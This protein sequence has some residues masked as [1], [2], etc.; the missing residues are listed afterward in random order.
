M[1]NIGEILVADYLRYKE[2][3]DF[4]DFN[5]STTGIQGEIDVVGLN[6]K[7]KV[8]FICEVAVHLVS[9][10]RYVSKSQPNT[11][12]KLLNK[13]SKDIGYAERFF[14]K[15]KKV[16][17]L[18]SPLVKTSKGKENQMG[19]IQRLKADLKKEHGVEIKIFVN[20]EFRKAFEFLRSFAHRHKPELKSPVMR[21]LQIDAKTE[22]FSK[23]IKS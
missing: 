5:V 23:E 16:F 10:L 22:R 13:F 14:P 19:T 18:W 9:G 1:P 11:Y 6:N 17:M 2:G 21:V 7:E 12:N 8:V 20:E 4:V 3:C 15:Y